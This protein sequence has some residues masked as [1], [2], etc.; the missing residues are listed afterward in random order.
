MKISWLALEINVYNLWEPFYTFAE[1][2]E[3]NE[4]EEDE[5]DNYYD[6]EKERDLFLL[7]Q[8]L[9]AYNNFP[10]EISGQK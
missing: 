4:D 5:E 3:D 10:G 1:E 7:Q 9:F 8:K 2:I 6:C